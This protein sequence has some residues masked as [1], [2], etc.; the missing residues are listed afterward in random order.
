MP[1]TRS[2]CWGVTNLCFYH[3][4]WLLW[5]CQ[6]LNIPLRDILRQWTKQPWK[7]WQSRPRESVSGCGYRG[8]ARFSDSSRE[9]GESRRKRKEWDWRWCGRRWSRSLAANVG[10]S[11]FTSTER[12][13]RKKDGASFFK[14]PFKHAWQLLEYKKCGKL[15]T[16]NEELEQ[17]FRGQ[18][19]NIFL[20][21]NKKTRKSS[22]PGPNGMLLKHTPQEL[23]LCSND[24][25]DSHENC[26]EDP[27]HSIVMAKGCSGLYT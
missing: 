24:L 2:Y 26:S 3:G 17:H 13:K 19:N 16:T 18:N 1:P 5:L 6:H 9:A 10:H 21:K 11:G 14:N 20:K 23:S 4:G 27:A 22:A 15:E 8:R 12:K 7:S 25:V